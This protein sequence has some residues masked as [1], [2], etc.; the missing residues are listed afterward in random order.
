[1]DHREGIIN[2]TVNAGDDNLAM[3]GSQ[4]AAND[5]A[6]GGKALPSSPEP[7]TTA[8]ERWYIIDTGWAWGGVRCID[9]KV[10]EAAPV[11]SKFIG[12]QIKQLV[13]YYKV[14]EI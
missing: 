9:G 12:Q 10:V 1:M 2:C 5:V 11:F 4:S 14:Y 8:T 6:C 3:G 13:N 7:A